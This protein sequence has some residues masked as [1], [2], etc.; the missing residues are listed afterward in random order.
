MKNI[1]NFNPVDLGG[2]SVQVIDLNKLV[3]NALYFEASDISICETAKKIYDEED[4]ESTPE[5]IGAV[6]NAVR[7]LAPWLIIQL[8]K[9]LQE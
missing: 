1:K 8:V 9:Y 7:K 6:N 3:G 4:F 5:L 2:N